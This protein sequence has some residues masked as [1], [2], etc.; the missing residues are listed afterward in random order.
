MMC[1]WHDNF[2]TSYE[3]LNKHVITLAP[4]VSMNANSDKIPVKW[5]H[6]KW[7]NGKILFWNV[8]NKNLTDFDGFFRGDSTQ[9]RIYPNMEECYILFFFSENL[10]FAEKVMNKRKVSISLGLNRSECQ[11]SKTGNRCERR[12][13]QNNAQ[14]L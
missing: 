10:V 1:N 2:I 5:T 3:F 11:H 4:I 13:C 8:I 7:M 9:K 6:H 14:K 12:E